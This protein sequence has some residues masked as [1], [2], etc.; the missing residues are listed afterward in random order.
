MAKTDPLFLLIKSLTKSEKRHFRLFT[1]QN[2]REGNKDYLRLF[3]AIE[4]QDEYDEEAIVE[5]FKGEPYLK[6]LRAVKFYLNQQIIKCLKNIYDDISQTTR[7]HHYMLEIEVLYKRRLFT[8]CSH[9]IQKAKAYAYKYENLPR[10]L[11]LLS[12]ESRIAVWINDVSQ[13]E[14]LKQKWMEE[15]KE[16]LNKYNEIFELRQFHHDIYSFFLRKGAAKT[17][18]ET[19]Y[20]E[21]VLQEPVLGSSKTSFV[22]EI[23]RI[24]MVANCLLVLG[25]AEERYEMIR[26]LIE[27]FD[28]HPHQL[29]ER[30]NE[31][32]YNV[33]VLANL[34]MTLRKFSYATQLMERM[35]QIYETRY[36]RLEFVNQLGHL[37]ISVLF[38]LQQGKFKEALQLS[39]DIDKLIAN[40]AQGIDS[41][42]E[43]Y[44]HEIHSLIYFNNRNYKRA[45]HH[46]QQIINSG[47]D[48]RLD[49][50]IQ[51]RITYLIIQFEEKEFQHLDYMW[52]STYRYLLKKERLQGA[53][54]TVLKFLRG[55]KRINS[56]KEIIQALGEFKQLIAPYKH[57]FMLDFPLTEWIDS[58]L[59]NRPL[60]EIVRERY[61]EA[62]VEGK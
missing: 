62:L 49:M 55:V 28:Q 12:W 60:E 36:N 21:S 57:E 51:A 39:A 45:Q 18:K 15:E 20:I 3:D 24:S 13:I 34:A 59:H 10:M 37:K 19:Q 38:S 40:N 33:R 7:L 32:F 30:L 29:E 50:Q 22:G 17:E 9:T 16:V 46:V 48:V 8:N 58:K 61:Q 47:E 6:Q 52:R 53:E 44:V 31:Y 23:F 54:T 2:K 41:V 56:E 4:A 35:N 14:T 5:Q 43:L 11:E 25:R 26:R 42:E 1:A 27:L